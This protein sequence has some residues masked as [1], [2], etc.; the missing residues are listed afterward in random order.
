MCTKIGMLAYS[1]D[2][3]RPYQSIIPYACGIHSA[4]LRNLFRTHTEYEVDTRKDCGRCGIPEKVDTLCDLDR[5]WP[6][7]RSGSQG[8]FASHCTQVEALRASTCA[9][10]ARTSAE[11]LKKAPARV[12]FS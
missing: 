3:G 1:R 11:V 9:Y 10:L 6:T 5:G 7:P 4:G 2:L 8:Y 12:P